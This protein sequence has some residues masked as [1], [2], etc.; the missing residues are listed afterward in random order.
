MHN[1][2]CLIPLY[3]SWRFRKIIRA[4]IDAHLN[5][6]ASIIV[7]DRHSFDKTIDYL[8]HRYSHNAQIT[9]IALNDEVDWVDNINNMIEQVKSDFFRIIPH[10]DTASSKSSELL[11][12][13]LETNNGAVLASGI[14][15]AKNLFNF[16]IPKRDELNQSEYKESL[17]WTINDAVSVYSQS[18]FAGAFK[19]VIRTKSIVQTNVYIKKTPSLVHSERTWLFALAMLGKFCFVPQS[20][21][22]K[23]YYSNSTQKSWTYSDQ[24]TIDAANVMSDY[25]DQILTDNEVIKQTKTLMYLNAFEKIRPSK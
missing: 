5:H 18:R 19:G 7:S 25:C 3:R 9:F 20:I 13:A 12:K 6:G 1:L 22:I 15:H 10:D 17:D 11:L 16:R 8:K 2:T 23:R 14:V 4:N 21:L 24:A